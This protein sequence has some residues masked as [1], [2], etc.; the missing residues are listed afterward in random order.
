MVGLFGF[1]FWTAHAGTAFSTPLGVTMTQAH[2][3][4]LMSSSANSSELTKISAVQHK[5]QK[6]PFLCCKNSFGAHKYP[7]LVV[8]RKCENSIEYFSHLKESKNV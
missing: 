6:D 4:K 2:L 7:I 3:N 8:E 1:L 5:T